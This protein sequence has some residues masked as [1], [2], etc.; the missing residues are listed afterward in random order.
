MNTVYLYY[1][2]EQGPIFSEKGPRQAWS[3]KQLFHNF[4]I[5]KSLW[6]LHLVKCLENIGP[7]SI[8]IGQF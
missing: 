1:R 6:K 3:I 7:K 2:K 5:N 8:L 4:I